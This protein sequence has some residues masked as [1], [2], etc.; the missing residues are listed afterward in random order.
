MSTEKEFNRLIDSLEERKEHNDGVI[1]E[2]I[3]LLK[4]RI[5]TLEYDIF[6]LNGHD[7]M[8]E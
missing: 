3:M 5:D 6:V 7:P 2:L 1:L 8:D 4:N